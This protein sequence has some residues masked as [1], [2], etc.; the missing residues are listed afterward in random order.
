MPRK[1]TNWYVI[2]GGP[3]SGKT[4][5]IHL[6]EERGY[7]TVP[8][9]A[10]HLIDT[11]LAKGETLTS[12]HAD[13]I[14]FQQTA[15]LMQTTVESHLNPDQVIFLDRAIPDMLAYYR[16]NKIAE[17]KALTEAMASCSYKKVFILDPL[18]IVSDYAR[19]ETKEAQGRIHE[20]VV[21]AYSSLPFPVVHVPVLPPNER[22]LFVLD[23]L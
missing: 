2:S 21:A 7:A 18:P 8:E 12:I 5:L 6:L 23:R 16:F 15:L 20:E 19:R 1:D 13:E 9:Q 10:R 17:D 11:R 3:S 14:A 22:L 4:T